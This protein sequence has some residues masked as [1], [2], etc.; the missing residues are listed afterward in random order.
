MRDRIAMIMNE[1][2]NLI[3]LFAEMIYGP[4]KTI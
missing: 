3:Y 4:V 2:H 1:G